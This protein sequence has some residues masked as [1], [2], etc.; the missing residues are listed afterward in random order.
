M[1][2]PLKWASPAE[3]QISR[4]N[5]MTNDENI[6]VCGTDPFTLLRDIGVGFEVNEMRLELIREAIAELSAHQKK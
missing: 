5:P 4:I 6:R 2:A 3:P 1:S